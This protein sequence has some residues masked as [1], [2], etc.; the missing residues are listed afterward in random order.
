M[1]D[2]HPTSSAA[3][4]CL[5]SEAMTHVLTHDS[6][7]SLPNRLLLEDRIRQAILIEVGARLTRTL[8]EMDTLARYGSDEFVVIATG[9]EAL[10]DAQTVAQR[11]MTSLSHPVRVGATDVYPDASLGVSLYPAD[12]QDVNALLIHSDAA[13]SHAK[14]LG[15]RQIQ[16]F[17]PDMNSWTLERFQLTNELRHMGVRISIDDFGVNCSCLGYLRR[18]SL[19]ELK[20]DRSF[21]G[22]LTDNAGGGAIVGAIVT[23]AHG[24]GLKV[25]AEGVETLEQLS[26]I[27]QL[28]CDEYQ[29]AVGGDSRP[30]G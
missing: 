18:F 29:R 26:L 21:T 7:T 30:N 14:R 10:T 13:M 17:A 11:I 23:L 16:F 25:V 27:A 1:S 6:L 24:L 15:G 12:A 20:I 28:E 3:H 22:S 4:R 2:P 19:D 9:I 8:R 5:Q